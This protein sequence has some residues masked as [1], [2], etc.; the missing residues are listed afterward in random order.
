MKSILGIGN[1]LTDILAVLPDDT[2]LKEYHLPKGSMQHVDMET[3]DKIW[4]TLKEVGVKYVPGGSAA[5]TITCTA[6]FGMPSG[7]IGKIGNDELGHLFKSAME[8]FGVKTTMLYGTKAS[9]R[10]M[11]FIS[12]A[13]AERTFADYMGSAL[14]MGPDDLKQEYFEGYDY[15]H[16]EGYLVQNQDLI[17]KAVQMAKA[18][19]CK[20]SIDMASYNVVESNEAFLHNLVDNYVDIVFANE[21]EAKAFTKLEPREA[22]EELSKH[23]EIAVVKVGKDGSM[24]QQGDEY[25]FIEPWP[26]KAIDATG[27]GDTYAAGFL[28]AHSL[29]MPLKVCG[30]IGSI[31]AAKVVEVI[32]TKIDIPRWKD[33]KIEIKKLIAE[34]S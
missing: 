8:Q 15:F 9:G 2:L 6:I 27:A 34:N 12:G 17:L 22:L 10:C 3:G 31:I 18:A 26:A 30:E 4:S 25:Y 21:T 11:V 29:G 14:E 20:I 5:N 24:V 33:A 28:Y 32:G 23:C 19:G 13:N 1:A 16:I 7:Y